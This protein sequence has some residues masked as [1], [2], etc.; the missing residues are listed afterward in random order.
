[1]TQPAFE[2]GEIVVGYRP[3][4]TAATRSHV[5]EAVGASSYREMP[6]LDVL[7]LYP[8]TS[9]TEALE[10]VP[11]M[12]QVA[13]AEPNYRVSTEEEPNDPLYQ[14]AWSIGPSTASGHF[15]GIDTP[16]AWNVTV[17]AQN[18]SVAIVD[19]GIALTHPDL[20]A[21]LWTNPGE[22]GSGKEANGVDDD[23]NGF[24]DD[25]QGW[26]W[27]DADN[28]PDDLAGHGTMVA[29]TVGAHGNNATGA[30]GVSWRSKLASLRVLDDQGLGLTSDAASAFSYASSMGVDVVNASLT[31]TFPSVAM[32]TAITQASETLFVVA[33]GNNATNNDL[34]PK[35]PCN[36]A[37][38]NLLCVAA[39]DE[40]NALASFSN[41]G[42]VSVDLAAPGT[43]ILTT[44][45]DGYVDFYGTSA[46]TPHVA[47]VAVLLWSRHPDASVATISDAII[48][49]AEPLQTLQGK[50]ASGGRLN[51]AGALRQLGD[52][53]PDDR[54]S[55]RDNERLSDRSSDQNKK[56]CRRGKGKRGRRRFR[57]CK[58]R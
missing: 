10:R 44:H 27:I 14:E 31:S 39:T 28:N 29:G 7:E 11:Q 25:W 55:P 5:R 51:A 48:Q 50:T 20:V 17:G 13:Y 56:K 9:V 21:N 34:D 47:G 54:G 45:P 37:L 58:R 36:F 18:V 46:A 40:N 23:G 32:L 2:P 42:L 57:R 35:Y 22:T 12:R 33:A 1:M 41:H 16:S 38:P 8:G 52:Y 53:V 43:R 6:T 30:S 4:A 24:T 15:S 19:S 26:D 3:G 49:G